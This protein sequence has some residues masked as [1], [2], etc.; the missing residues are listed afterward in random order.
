MMIIIK[1]IRSTGNAGDEEIIRGGEDYEVARP[2]TEKELLLGERVLAGDI[3]EN[4]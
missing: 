4:E 1:Y 3:A 2:W